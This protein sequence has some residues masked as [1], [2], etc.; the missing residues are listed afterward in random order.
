MT[1]GERNRGPALGRALR[2]AVAAL[3]SVLLPP[4]PGAR[5]QGLPEP[6]DGV[7]FST[8]V[9]F[10]R[11]ALVDARDD[12]LVSL[13][14]TIFQGDLCFTS[15]PLTDVDA[16]HQRGFPFTSL[17]LLLSFDSTI[18]FANGVVAHPGDV[19][20]LLQ[21]GDGPFPDQATMYFDHAADGGLADSVDV[22]AITEEGENL[23]LSFESTT[24]LTLAP[25]VVAHDEDL[26]LF[27]L[28][29]Q[30]PPAIFF[31][32]S[33]EGVSA[34]LD[35][36]GADLRPDGR[37]A[38]SFDVA[39]TVPGIDGPIAFEDEDLLLFDLNEQRWSLL[40]DSSTFFSTLEPNDID[41]IAG[42]A[43]LEPTATATDTVPPTSTPT[44]TETP[45][46]GTETPTSTPTNTPGGPTDTP[47]A[48]A[49]STNTPGGPTDTPTATVTSSRTPGGPTDT[50]T[51]TVTSTNTP[52]GPTD[53]PTATAT[54]TRT[55]G[56]PT[57]TPTA[58]ATSTG[59]P[60]T[61][62]PG[63]CNGND[64]VDVAELI[65]GVNIALGRPGLDLCAQ[66][67]G[68]GSGTVTIDELIL[69]VQASLSSCG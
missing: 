28:S 23:L 31:D 16:A 55:P 35:L 30:N 12:C 42:V 5:A 17:L 10:D 51:A 61:D 63:D 43:L 47:T 11:D 45:P 49:T 38:V 40:L 54:L 57:D 19:V 20:S 13:S 2:L 21:G 3:A 69:A 53:T 34:A 25:L 14:N 22:D 60:R 33:A 50:P 7:V 46:P 56:G 27:D 18:R 65:R 52:G 37:L 32:G 41:A 48:T 9:H 36:D 26:V 1:S 8:D 62:C 64:V 24:V 67:D 68:D 29:G 4:V 15:L 59:T 39:G 58:T 6:L 44:P 66:F